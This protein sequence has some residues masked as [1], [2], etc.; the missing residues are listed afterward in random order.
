MRVEAP[1]MY[2]H[3]F[4]V[5]IIYTIV[6]MLRV[7]VVCL[8]TI[9][10][11]T[12]AVE[13]SHPQSTTQ[14]LRVDRYIVNSKQTIYKKTLA[15]TFAFLLYLLPDFYTLFIATFIKKHDLTINSISFITLVRSD[16]A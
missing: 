11:L 2:I 14:T 16:A 6:G 9:I 15:M 3:I 8:M 4:L 13:L 10:N 1:Y 12:I 5:C 7:R